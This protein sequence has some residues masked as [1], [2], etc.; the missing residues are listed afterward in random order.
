[1]KTEPIIT[2]I[3]AS[4]P[5]GR[6]KQRWERFPDGPLGAIL[7]VTQLIQGAWHPCSGGWYVS[8]LL[9]HSKLSDVIDIDF[10]QRWQASGVRRAVLACQDQDIR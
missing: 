6:C 10:G 5:G 9:E 7:G 8:T 2:H 3:D 1:M 4:M